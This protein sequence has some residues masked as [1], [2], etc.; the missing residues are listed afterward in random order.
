M[1]AVESTSALFLRKR[2]GGHSGFGYGYRDFQGCRD[3]IFEPFFTTKEVG[4]GMGLGL[5]IVYEIVVEHGGE[6]R[7]HS[8]QGI[9]TTFVVLLPHVNT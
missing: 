4:K 3:K 6:I 7:V 2:A 8:G 1:W 5:A 9:G